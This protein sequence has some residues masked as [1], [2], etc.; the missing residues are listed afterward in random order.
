MRTICF[1]F[2]ILATSSLDVSAQT[3]KDT[4][5]VDVNRDGIYAIVSENFFN[6]HKGSELYSDF[7]YYAK[8]LKGKTDMADFFV[9]N[10]VFVG[11]EKICFDDYTYLFVKN[12]VYKLEKIIVDNVALEHFKKME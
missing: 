8:R 2:M 1:V 12:G 11:E 5:N 4:L 7:S 3:L 9:A 6:E 10:I